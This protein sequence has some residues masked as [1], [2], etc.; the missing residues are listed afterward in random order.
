MWFTGVWALVPVT[1]LASQLFVTSTTDSG[2]AYPLAD[3]I[4]ALGSIALVEPLAALAGC[5]AGARL[6]RSQLLMSVPVY[7]SRVWVWLGLLSPVALTTTGVLVVNMIA[8]AHVT[9]APWHV[10]GRLV[11]VA[12]LVSTA[13]SSIGLGL[14]LV[15]RPIVAA[16]VAVLVPY[17]LIGFP[18]AME[19]YWL[20]H[21]TSVSTNCCQI[22][23]DL[24]IRA[25]LSLGLA[26]A[27]V[28]AAGFAMFVRAK[29][30]AR[31]NRSPVAAGVS[32]AALGL[33]AAM[34]ASPLGARAVAARPGGPTCSGVRPVA[35]CL[36]P[37]H[38]PSRADASR[39]LSRVVAVARMK[40]VRL[41]ATLTE[42]PGP[43]IRWPA[44][45][46]DLSPAWGQDVLARSVTTSLFPSTECTS[47]TVSEDA[48]AASGQSPS[49]TAP[50]VVA[51]W[52][53]VQLGID[54]A[55]QEMDPLVQQDYSALMTASE[56]DQVR[57]VN[58][59]IDRAASMCAGAR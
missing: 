31:G 2:V 39:L 12:F 43:G 29:S 4:R 10:D 41:P 37:E 23:E 25:L 34:V 54:P 19:P 3:E 8:A 17:L 49:A 5:L 22:Y 16:P 14:G 30:A 9:S 51:M 52:W 27:A 24:S 56:H 55:R 15:A 6:R 50:Y 40:H 42:L 33:T 13:Y 46:V 58:G 45:P 44:S 21:L 11:V 53:Q 32:A 35:L 1:L 57:W 36:W 59:A 47:S 20:R 26:M 7:R 18:P 28:T 38:E 48:P